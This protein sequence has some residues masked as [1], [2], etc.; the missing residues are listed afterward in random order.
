MLEVVGYI[1]SS[2]NMISMV[3]RIYH[4]IDW[5]KKS[6]AMGGKESLKAQVQMSW[7][8]IIANCHKAIQY[9]DVC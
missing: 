2:V 1:G 9:G 3:N 7:Q 8:S 4:E 6:R 5:S